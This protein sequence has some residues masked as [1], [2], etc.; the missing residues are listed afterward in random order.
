MING[1]VLGHLF[2]EGG[3]VE[4]FGLVGIARKA[5]VERSY[6]HPTASVGEALR[7]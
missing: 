6:V 2:N 1:A 7:Q 3:E 4:I 5:D